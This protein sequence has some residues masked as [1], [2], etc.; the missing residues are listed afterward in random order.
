MSGHPLSGSLINRLPNRFRL[1][2]SGSDSLHHRID[3]SAS[4]VLTWLAG[5][6]EIGSRAMLHHALRIPRIEPR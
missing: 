2:A 3:S 6:D 5:V 1:R 4:A